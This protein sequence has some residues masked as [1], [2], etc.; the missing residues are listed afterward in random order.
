M[1]LLDEKDPCPYVDSQQKD[2]GELIS[3]RA[4]PWAKRL[5]LLY[6]VQGLIKTFQSARA[7]YLAKPIDLDSSAE[8][9]LKHR[10]MV[11]EYQSCGNLLNFLPTAVFYGQRPS[12]WWTL[13]HDIDLL[14]GTYKYG[15]ANY[16]A[17]RQDK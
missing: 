7:K 16:Q 17:M 4:T 15:Y 11:L 14:I 8:D 2:W 3:Q 13:R 6:R 12:G 10:K 5:Q 1:S 9:Q